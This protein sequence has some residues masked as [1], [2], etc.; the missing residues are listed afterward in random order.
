MFTKTYHKVRGMLH[1]VRTYLYV[2]GLCNEDSLG[3]EVQTEDQQKTDDLN[4][5]PCTICVQEDRLFFLS[6]NN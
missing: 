3:C 6:S 4:I 2:A 5:S 1:E